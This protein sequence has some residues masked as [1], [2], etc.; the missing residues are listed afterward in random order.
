MRLLFLSFAFPLPA[1]NGHRMRT[2]SVLGALAAEGH[3]VMLL[4]FCQPGEAD[5]HWDTLKKVCQGIETVPLILPNLS[6]ATNYLDRV[7][8]SFVAPPYTIRRFSSPAMRARIEGHLERG[9]YE[10]IICDALYSAVNLP[11]TLVPVIL[12]SHNVEHILMKRYL[13][14]ERNPIRRFYAWSEMQRLRNWERSAC[15]RAAIVFTCSETDQQL[16]NDLVP[17]IPIAVVPNVVDVDSYVPREESDD[18]TLLFQGGM[19]WFPNRDAVS[20]LTDRILPLVRQTV[21]HIR[22]VVAGRNPSPA[23]IKRFA[24][25]LGIE[26]AGNVP[27]MRTEIAK[28]TVCVVP[29]R[30]ASGTR[31]KILEAAAMAKP[32][33]S[34]QIGAE[35]LDFVDGEEILLADDPRSFARAVTDLLADP[36]RRR[37]LGLAARRRVESQNDLL[38][39]QAALREALANLRPAS[40]PAVSGSEMNPLHAEAQP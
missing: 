4:S 1:N 40:V 28:A 26:F 39:L 10:A 14:I 25:T 38:H 12:N 37:T 31:L 6:S 11:Q 23:F 22:F 19:D 7:L 29:L 3:D 9:S 16:L 20:F 13:S 33:V 21:P 15:R 36:L 5:A 2:W 8:R 35:G 32:I 18:A 24:S 30:I 34:T 17:G 27:D